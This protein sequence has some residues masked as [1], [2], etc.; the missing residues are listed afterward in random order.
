ML[1]GRVAASDEQEDQHQQRQ[2]PQQL[3]AEIAAGAA[4]VPKTTTAVT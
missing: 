4:T 1:I 3:T 2:R